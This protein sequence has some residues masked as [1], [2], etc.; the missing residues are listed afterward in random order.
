VVD[1]NAAHRVEFRGIVDSGLSCR[2]SA[3]SASRS[4]LPGGGAL[5]VGGDVGGS[6]SS[7]S[8]LYDATSNQWASAGA[9][10][11]P[12]MAATAVGLGDG[13]VLV[14]GGAEG[15]LS[16]TSRDITREPGSELYSATGRPVSA[17]VSRPVP[18]PGSPWL[19]VGLGGLVVILA[20]V[21]AIFRRRLPGLH[22]DA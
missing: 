17:S 21:A 11:S 3:V 7:A 20:A 19:W 12:R 1:A 2:P 14:A 9:L 15:T 22:R 16:S 4:G 13:E 6:A 10:S 8:E 18:P 5:A